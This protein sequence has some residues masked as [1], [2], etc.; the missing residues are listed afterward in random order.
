MKQK[1]LDWLSSERNYKEGV[2]LYNEYGHSNTLK[3]NFNRMAGNGIHKTL[4]Y[5]LARL[6]GL[7]QKQLADIK[8]VTTPSQPAN[9]VPFEQPKEKKYIDDLL[10]E[11]AGKFGVSVDEL[12]TSE[13]L[14]E[15][16]DEE[17]Q[18]AIDFLKP[19]YK[20]VSETIK[21][22]IRIRETYPFLKEKDCPNELH[23]L[24]GKMFAAYD[25]YREAYSKL[26]PDNPP[27]EAYQ[28]AEKIVENYLE[29]RQ[30]WAELD[31]YLEHK[32]F[33]GEHPLF[34]QKTLEEE[35]AAIPD[36][37]LKPQLT[38]AKASLGRAKSDLKKAKEET[39][40]SVEERIKK[41]E[42]RVSA[43]EKEIEKRKN[44]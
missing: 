20:E 13:N 39:R 5:E 22:V 12:F 24:T 3:Q 44:V 32:T 16:A 15:D 25:N 4:V 8:Q 28:L 36:I 26:S 30:I 19:K 41:F 10:I 31:Y 23:I 27:D 40:Q 37:E 21:R 7:S 34:T 35:M 42:E 43:L 33:L 17:Q 38:A 29:N 18:A 9:V 14:P 2:K 1:I 11:L 6:I